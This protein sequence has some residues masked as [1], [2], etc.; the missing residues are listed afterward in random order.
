V[1]P[2][3]RSPESDVLVAGAGAM[4]AEH[5]KTLL[6]CGVGAER[7]VVAARRAEQAQALAAL[8][9]VRAVRLEEVAAETAIVAVAEDA[10]VPVAQALLARGASRILIEKPGALAAADLAALAGDDGVFVAYNRRFYGSVVRARELVEQDGGAIAAT[11]DFT[12]VERLVLA[13]AERRGLPRRTL[14]RWGIANSLHVIDLAFFLAGDPETIVTERAGG[15]PWH[16]AGAR[17]AGSGTTVGSAL[18]AYAASW[19]GAGRW[20]VEVTTRERR[21]VLRPLE[22]LHEQLRGSFALA[23]VELQPEPEGMKPGLAG[24]LEAFL[25]RDDRFLCGVREAV[26]RLELAERIFGYG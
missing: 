1:T 4:A 23:P 15:L 11:F 13:D 8:H 20:G 25:S 3:L 17:F 10:L 26:A 21:L 24:Q 2:T 12:E 16:P 19:D 5:V 22:E 14:H 18:F 9:R 7:I 6:A